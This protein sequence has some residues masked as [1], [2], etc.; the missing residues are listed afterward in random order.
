[1]EGIKKEGIE[2]P[3]KEN[4]NKIGEV[5]SVSR[6]LETFPNRVYRSVRDKA[7][8][9]DLLQCGV[10]R[11]KQ[12]AGLVEKSRW[13]DNVYWSRGGEGKYHVVQNGGYVIE[14][15]Y[16][17]AKERE[18]RIDDVT[19]LYHKTE[20]GELREVLEEILSSKFTKI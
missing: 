11:N 20:A 4:P 3:K 15:P 19:A 12:S 8:I 6:D 7:A 16:D 13:G 18:V 9:D 14:A 5:L 17:I 2:K 1:M 10:V